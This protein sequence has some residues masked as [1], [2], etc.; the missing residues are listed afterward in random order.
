MAAVLLIGRAASN[1]DDLDTVLTAFGHTVTNSTGALIVA[2]PA[3]L[4]GFDVII[5]V[6]IVNGASAGESETVAQEILDLFS[7]TGHG[8]PETP[9]ILVGSP[10]GM[11]GGDVVTNS[12]ACQL[13]II[14][15]E[16]LD[17]RTGGEIPLDC[18]DLADSWR[19]FPFTN[20]FGPDIISQ[21][22]TAS[23]DPTSDSPTGTELTTISSV[24][25]QY[26]AFWDP[27]DTA[28]LSHIPHERVPLAGATVLRLDRKTADGLP[29]GQ[30]VRATEALKGKRSTVT[31]SEADLIW[32]GAYTEDMTDLT[33]FSAQLLH[34]A[35]EWLEGNLTET[36]PTSGTQ[37]TILLGVDLDG[38]GLYVT[39]SVSWTETLPSGTS[40]VVETAFV[41]A[42]VLGAFGS[43]T[44]GGVPNGI[45]ATDP[46]ANVQVL[47]RITMATSNS[48]NTPT[49]TDFKMTV[50]G[51]AAVLTATPTDKF[52]AGLLT[53]TSGLNEGLSQEIKDYTPG[54]QRIEFFEEALKTIAVCDQFDILPGCQKR[55]SEDCNDQYDNILNYRG[56]NLLPGK[57]RLL[58][59][60]DST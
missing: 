16:E 46:L 30:V 57:D 53:W 18:V 38:L 42:G 36:Y 1:L 50:Q 3:L 25:G 44:S 51:D 20:A 9:G 34:G 32:I 31:S 12:V 8:G 33:G 37:R 26:G 29:C 43:V 11:S 45:T 13:G 47:V 19:D 58:G 27:G 49:L 55:A 60:P 10:D 40:I 35:V 21:D 22:E 5:I 54:T 28:V 4:E 41:E 24:D 52:R 23:A 48:A 15:A 2:T 56:E 14:G 17:A 39:G 59:Y 6:G 7:G